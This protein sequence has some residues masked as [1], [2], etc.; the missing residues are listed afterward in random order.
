M[1]GRRAR[2]QRGEAP[3]GRGRRRGRGVLG[4]RPGRHPG[5]RDPGSLA[6]AGRGVSPS[7]A[8]IGPPALPTTRPAGVDPRAVDFALP[9]YLQP[10]ASR[11]RYIFR[12][13][14]VTLWREKFASLAVP[15][16]PAGEDLSHHGALRPMDQRAVDAKAFDQSLPKVILHPE[17]LRPGPLVTPRHL[18]ALAPRCPPAG[19]PR[20][21]TVLHD[22][23]PAVRV[24]TAPPHQAAPPCH[25]RSGHTP[26]RPG[27]SPPCSEITRPS[28]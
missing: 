5:P 17:R 22:G 7:P 3:A 6:S 10:P 28:R 14:I 13:R 25:R 24:T 21:R 18:G 27:A 4:T 2:G 15:C 9:E 16:Q 1:P 12:R 23:H 11:S 20:L 26:F 19:P 8:P